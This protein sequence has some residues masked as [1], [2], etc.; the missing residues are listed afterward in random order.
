MDPIPPP[1]PA[2][3]AASTSA[4]ELKS[5]ESADMAERGGTATIE[6]MK[7]DESGRTSARTS[8]PHQQLQHHIIYVTS[9]LGGESEALRKR[10]AQGII[11]TYLSIW[12]GLEVIVIAFQVTFLSVNS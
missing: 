10:E 12:L 8:D 6:E 1:I 7:F 4:E 5:G 2:A 3:I 11:T 9:Q